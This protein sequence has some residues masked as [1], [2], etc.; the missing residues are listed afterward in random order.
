MHA[1]PPPRSI[2]VSLASAAE[3]E[4]YLCQIIESDYRFLQVFDDAPDAIVQVDARGVI[5]I[6]NRTAEQMFGYSRAELLG[7]KVDLLIP[8]ANRAAHA[9]HMDDFVQ[10]GRTLRPM[11]KGPDG[12]RARAGKREL[13]LNES[14]L[15]LFEQILHGRIN[16]GQ[17]ELN[18]S[19]GSAILT[20]PG[21]RE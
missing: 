1:Q 2:D 17:M 20:C 6:A 12:L 19:A 8:E 13:R 18:A 15:D 14:G 11:G 7:S 10:S 5:V 3:R 21:T 4:K 16:C 9:A